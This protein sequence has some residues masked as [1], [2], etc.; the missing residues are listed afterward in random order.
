MSF[1]P[2]VLR[3]IFSRHIFSDFL[4]VFGAKKASRIS[5]PGE[6]NYNDIIIII[7]RMKRMVLFDAVEAGT[8]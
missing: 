8:L 4:L 2:Y 3:L 6:I 7:L 5:G 1:T